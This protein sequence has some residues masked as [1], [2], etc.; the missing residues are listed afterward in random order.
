M[1]N[2]NNLGF[3]LFA[4]IIIC[5]I[6]GTNRREGLVE[7][8]EVH[9]VNFL[10]PKIAQHGKKD[11]AYHPSKI[12]LDKAF[13]SD[14]TIRTAPYSPLAQKRPDYEVG[15]TQDMGM[16]ANPKRLKAIESC[17]PSLTGIYDDC[18][19]YG[20]NVDEYKYPELHEVFNPAIIK[21]R[22]IMTSRTSDQHSQK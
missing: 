19:P 10:A 8:E 2:K 13:L 20:W 17:R 7:K 16:I 11:L 3:F 14:W 22:P 21:S 1:L 15:K 18:G 12:S 6:I 5:L 9:T 4:L